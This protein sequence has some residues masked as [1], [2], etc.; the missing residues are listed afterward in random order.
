MNTKK[1]IGALY[2]LRDRLATLA[3]SYAPLE[4]VA[5]LRTE[6]LALTS[7]RDGILVDQIL[8]MPALRTLGESL[9]R[10]NDQAETAIEE[11]FANALMG[12]ANPQ[13]YLRT[14][15]HYTSYEHLTRHLEEAVRGHSTNRLLFIGSGSFPISAILA[16]NIFDQIDCLDNNAEA[17]EKAKHIVSLFRLEN[18]IRFIHAD[19]HTFEDLESYDVVMLA[20]LVGN[21]PDDKRCMLGKLGAH[22]RSGTLLLARTSHGLRTLVYP[23]VPK[24]T[25]PGF[26]AL[27]VTIAGD[28]CMNSLV[29][30]QKL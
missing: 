11:Q 3:P 9:R 17:N 12:C 29:S 5:A 13:A 6:L 2:A 7:P 18:H 26:A 15:P 30:A 24:N 20:S 10:L 14:F 8:A 27:R 23:E 16:A 28:E 4:E 21:T 25:W 19:V 22:M 1:T